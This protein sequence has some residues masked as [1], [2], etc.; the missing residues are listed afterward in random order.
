MTKFKLLL[1]NPILDSYKHLLLNDNYVTEILGY[2]P[3]IPNIQNK[4]FIFSCFALSV[5]GK[6]YYPDAR[7]GFSIAS[8]NIHATEEEKKADLF[9]LMLAR[10][11]ADAIIVGSNSLKNEHG[12][13]LPDI[14]DSKLQNIH[15]NRTGSLLPTAFV[16]C[17]DLSNI[18]FSDKLFSNDS[19]QVVI[20]CINNHVNLAKLPNTYEQINFTNWIN[21]QALKLKNIL[22]CNTLDELILKMHK[23]GFNIILNESPYFHHQLL[24]L[25]LLDEIWVNYSGSYI[26]G[27]LNGLGGA[28]KPFNSNNHPDCELLTLH[29][30]GYNFIYTRQK[31]LY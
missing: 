24:Q 17:R 13:F 27:N 26:G 15:Y 30:I 20:C 18:N 7:S 25:K 4:P 6:L 12:N 5:D 21:K 10:T 16:I 29:T 22:I 9:I 31:I 1:K 14:A 19:H 11:I 2:A 8:S 28:Q 23:V 3:A